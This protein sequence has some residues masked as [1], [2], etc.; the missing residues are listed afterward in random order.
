MKGFIVKEGTKIQVQDTVK[1]RGYWKPFDMVTTKENLFFSEDIVID[2]IGKIGCHK[3]YKATV[4][5]MYAEGGYYGFQRMDLDTGR[6]DRYIML[7]G[8]HQVEVH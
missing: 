4:G 8:L 2:P 3:G 5:G 6:R 1:S 7:V